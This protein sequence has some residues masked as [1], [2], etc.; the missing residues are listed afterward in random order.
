MIRT[1]AM[2][3]TPK[4]ATATLATYDDGDGRGEVIVRTVG[5]TGYQ[6]RNGCRITSCLN[7]DPAAPFSP[8]NYMPV[9]GQLVRKLPTAGVPQKGIEPALGGTPRHG[10]YVQKGFRCQRRL[11]FRI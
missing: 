6:F 4:M 1:M 5:D 11:N 2:M 7:E 8:S 3:T 9:V 10:K